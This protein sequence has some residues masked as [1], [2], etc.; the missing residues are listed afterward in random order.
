MWLTTEDPKEPKNLKKRL[1]GHWNALYG[2]YHNNDF[3]QQDYLLYGDDAFNWCLLSLVGIE[4]QANIE[5]QWIKWFDAANPQFGY[6]K[7][8]WAVG[9]LGATKD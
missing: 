2:N 6:N 7:T 4:Q 5:W 9:V 3:L 1:F 8:E